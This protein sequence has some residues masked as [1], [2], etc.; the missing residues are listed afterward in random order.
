MNAPHVR[1]RFSFCALLA[2]ALALPQ[3]RASLEADTKKPYNLQIVLYVGANRVFTPLFQEN[4]QRE[5][6]NQ[7]NMT[8]GDLARVE[9]TR[10]HPLLRDVETKGLDS[11]LEGIDALSERTTHFV[12][13]DYSKGAYQ[14]QTRFHEGL[15]GQAGPASTRIATHDRASLARIIGQLVEASFC[16]VGTVA[17]VGKD[18]SLKLKGGE[19]GTGL[20]RWV[21]KGQVFA[22]SR[23]ADEGGRRKAQR[24]E[25]AL[26]EVLDAPAGGV[27]RCRYW[28]RYQEDAL[29]IGPGTLGYRAQ[30]LATTPG[31]VKVQL[32]DDA[33]LAP[34]DGVRLRVQGPGAGKPAELLTNRDGL[35]VTRENFSHLAIVQV[36]SGEMVR[37]QFPVELVPGR[38]AVARVTMQAD[39]ESFAPF[40]TRRDA[41]LRRV[42]DNVRMSTERSRD[43]AAQLHQSLEAALEAGK[44]SL[45]ALQAEIDYLDGERS[46][47]AKLAKEKKWAF[48]AREGDQEIAELRKKATELSEFVGRIERVLKEA[49][50]EK[51]LGLVKLLERARLLE[52]E[53]D[54]DQAIRLYEQVVQASP[55]EKTVQ[56]HLD[57]LKADWAPVNAAHAEARD[58][59]MRT[60]PALGVA[61]LGKNM[62]KASTSLA[63]CK[64]AGDRLTP[65]K[66]VR[67]NAVHMVNLKKELDTLKR[68]DVEDNRNRARTLAPTGE[69]L[70]RLHQDATAWLEA[71]K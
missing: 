21:Q 23:I 36:L 44:K 52:G 51:T 65:L 7:L 5:L 61:D 8:F 45:P 58:F 38:T 12:L 3:A 63:I 6:A 10:S 68:R 15:T 18:V 11:A 14:I 17:T 50:G 48:D 67:A 47:L 55:G 19:L 20:E 1:R 34:L 46:Q 2:F 39:G 16:P 62:E 4:L 53:A 70:V 28:H 22:V 64:A 35:A 30:R 43:L 27:C 24:L 56:A 32:L 57:K 59:L 71:R 26:L 40:A 54:F 33:T 25:W 41:W 29:T 37:A 9:V 66:L 60:W 13:L 31:P 49:G 42:Y 69:A